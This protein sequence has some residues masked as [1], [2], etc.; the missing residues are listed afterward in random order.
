[1]TCKFDFDILKFWKN[2]RNFEMYFENQESISTLPMPFLYRLRI[3]RTDLEVDN[4]GSM[5]SFSGQ[6]QRRPS[7]CWRHF[8]RYEWMNWIFFWNYEGKNTKMSTGISMVFK[9]ARRAAKLNVH[10]SVLSPATLLSS[11]GGTSSNP[12]EKTRNFLRFVFFWAILSYEFLKF[13]PQLES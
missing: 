1:V 10:Q 4:R 9:R 6:P 11:A 12:A 13:P 7:E 2:F 5:G 8:R 3:N